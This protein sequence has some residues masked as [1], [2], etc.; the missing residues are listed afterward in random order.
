M[1][2]LRS[3]VYENEPRDVFHTSQPVASQGT[4][5]STAEQTKQFLM[6]LASKTDEQMQQ[7]FPSIAKEQFAELRTSHQIPSP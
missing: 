7:L 5:G 1:S 6:L 2:D 3:N 4:T